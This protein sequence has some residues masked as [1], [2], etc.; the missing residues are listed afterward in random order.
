MDPIRDFLNRLRHGDWWTR[1]EVIEQLVCY[2]E[3]LYIGVLEEWLRTDQD[4]DLRSAS[5]E[6]YAALG[7]RAF[8]SLFNLM[9]DPEAEVRSFA[10]NVLG[11]IA[12]PSSIEPLK[13]LLKDP[14]EKV[15]HA[16]AEALG[17][18]GEENTVDALACKMNDAPW[19]AMAAIA[20]LGEIGGDK[21]R[22][23][24]HDALRS[25][26]FCGMACSALEKAGTGESIGLLV[27]FLGRPE[28]SDFAL[29]AI[30]SIA[31]REGG[32][33][34][35]SSIEALVPLL[36]EFQKSG[37]DDIKRA[38]TVALSWSSDP[39]SAPFLVDALADEDVQEYAVRG[40]VSL[41]RSA[42]PFLVGALGK[43]GRYR[44]ILAK[45]LSMAGEYA[46]L[47]PFTADEDPEV[48]TE[49]ALA[50][51]GM[52]TAAASDALS[53]LL[54]DPVEEVR[55]AAAIALKGHS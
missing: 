17:K 37:R 8:G 6:V 26:E 42:V 38:A 19:V 12:D 33:L 44:V 27:P 48:R 53:K 1:K 11:D 50:L 31:E 16:A 39:R 28:V 40:L 35:S 29:K 20:A 15:R 5:L 9:R 36:I 47:L 41:G 4:A 10:A 45:A 51:A 55:A 7:P 24:L 14:D 13:R 2:P 54:R 34:P 25:E 43:G 49:A 21:A 52:N 46:A 18:I 23:L 3:G 32:S 30:V 22:G